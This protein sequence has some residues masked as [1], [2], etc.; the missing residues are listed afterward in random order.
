MSKI[1]HILLVDDNE[2]DN[3]FHE[4]VIGQTGVAVELTAIDDSRK[5]IEYLEKGINPENDDTNTLPDIVFLDI[6]MPAVNGFELLDSFRKIPDPYHRK[7]RIKFFIL[8]SDPTTT[9]IIT[10]TYGDLIGKYLAKPLTGA[11]FLDILN[12]HAN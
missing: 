5:A 6:N 8:S 3:K 4:R 12:R 1:P 10:K 2:A 7:K 11:V 9:P